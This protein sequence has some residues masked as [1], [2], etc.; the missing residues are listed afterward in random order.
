MSTADAPLVFDCCRDAVT[1]L[2]EAGADLDVV[3]RAIETYGLDRD[4]KDALWLWLWGLSRPARSA[5]RARFATSGTTGVPRDAGQEARA[6]T[7][8]LCSPAGGYEQ[9]DFAGIRP[10]GRAGSVPRR[11]SE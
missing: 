4:E 7:T 5:A 3:E 10:V 2:V 8:R 1:E 9:G 11:G 6:S